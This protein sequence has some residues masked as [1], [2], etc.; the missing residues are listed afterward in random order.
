MFRFTIRDVLW[1]TVVVALAT[2][3]WVEH[4]SHVF[5]Y[6]RLREHCTVVEWKLNTLIDGLKPELTVVFTNNEARFIQNEPVPSLRR[7]VATEKI[8]ADWQRD[9]GVIK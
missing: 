3:W 1:L 8:P 9:I 2:G 7:E 5:A 6:A 4:R